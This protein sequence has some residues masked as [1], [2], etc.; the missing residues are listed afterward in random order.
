MIDPKDAVACPTLKFHSNRDEGIATIRDT[1]IDVLDVLI[2]L[3]DEVPVQMIRRIFPAL[4]DEDIETCRRF[5]IDR[6]RQCLARSCNEEPEQG[7]RRQP[8]KGTAKPTR[9]PRPRGQ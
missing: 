2:L 5:L 4:D 6:I 9:R 7:R 8:R 3:D 1:G